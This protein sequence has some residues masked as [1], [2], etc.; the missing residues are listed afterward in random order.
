[1][2][3][4]SYQELRRIHDYESRFNYLKLSG[5]VG[6]ETF[7]FDR[8]LNQRFYT[9]QAWKRVRN[10]VIVRDN[11]CDLGV[12]GYEIRSRIIIHHMNPIMVEDLVEFNPEVLNPNFLITTTHKTHNA[13]HFGDESQLLRLPPERSAGDTKL[14]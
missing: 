4:R 10:E 6:M 9:S 13:I 1:M 7:G 12:D 3:I 8:H 11:G 5:A 2:T 14:W